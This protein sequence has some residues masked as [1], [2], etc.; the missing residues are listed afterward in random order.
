M[1][2]T[3]KYIL[4][5]VMENFK[6]AETKH[7]IIIALN[8]ALI[9]LVINFSVYKNTFIKIL[10]YLTILFCGIS[11]IISFFALH[12]R[13]EKV[14][15]KNRG[16]QDKNLLYYHNLANMS[17]VELLANIVEFYNFPKNYKYDNLDLDLSSTI[18]ANSKII[19]TKFR[20]FNKSTLF[21]VI[22]IISALVMF[23]AIGA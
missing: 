1:K 20:L 8:G 21:C 4:D 7:S 5:Y 3:L 2:Q 23:F 18:V 10:N 6:I 15:F 22:G 14:K 12:S 19:E 11:I 13:N 16:T 9:A 17:S